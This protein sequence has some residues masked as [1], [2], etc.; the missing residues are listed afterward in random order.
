MSMDWNSD[1]QPKHV[2]VS[3][4]CD[5]GPRLYSLCHR[6]SYILIML[7]IRWYERWDD[8]SVRRYR[9]LNPIIPS[10]TNSIRRWIVVI[11]LMTLQ[12]STC[13]LVS[14]S[15]VLR[16]KYTYNRM[17][18]LVIG[19]SSSLCHM[20]RLVDTTNTLWLRPKCQSGPCF[21]AI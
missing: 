4:I 3:D 16:H 18:R 15:L 14:L 9:I 10:K 13:I 7:L 21:C 20:Q 5:N 6:Y 8:P 2:L 1:W 11:R 19:S 12:E 17:G